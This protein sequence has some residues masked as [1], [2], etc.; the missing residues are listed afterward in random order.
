LVIWFC[1]STPRNCFLYPFCAENDWLNY[2][3][4]CTC[5]PDTKNN[6]DWISVATP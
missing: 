5:N 6:S 1:V 4:K 2:I 3:T